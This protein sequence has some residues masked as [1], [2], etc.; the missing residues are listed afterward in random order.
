[1]FI[2]LREVWHQSLSTRW[3]EMA[4]FGD[5]WPRILS[6]AVVVYLHTDC[7]EAW[8]R[9]VSLSH[10]V[11]SCCH[12]CHGCCDCHGCCGFWCREVVG[13]GDKFVATATV[14]MQN[15]TSARKWIVLKQLTYWT[16]W[17]PWEIMCF[18]NWH[19]PGIAALQAETHTAYPQSDY[20]IFYGPGLTR[21]AMA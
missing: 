6:A 21:S 2:E 4:A 3:R 7:A 17:T 20:G 5:G 13:G 19:L 9:S 1:M 12:G 11:T 16:C 8:Q 18:C 10:F 14:E 15:T